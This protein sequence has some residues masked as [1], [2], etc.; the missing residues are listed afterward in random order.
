MSNRIRFDPKYNVPM[1]LAEQLKGASSSTRWDVVCIGTDRSTGD[2]LGPLTGSLLRSLSPRGMKVWGDV[3]S[4]I[5]A[6]NLARFL[7]GFKPAG[8]VL[9]IDACLG[10]RKHV[11]TVSFLDKPLLPGAGVRKKLPS[12]GDF[13]I[14]GTVNVGGFMEFQVLQNTRL[15]LVL[16]MADWIA[17]GISLAANVSAAGLLRGPVRRV[18]AEARD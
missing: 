1:D 5:H 8:P 15:S 2:A 17:E 4:P 6:G 13:H 16:S 14:T 18:R 7:R 12:I 10:A 11:G 3:H 9:A